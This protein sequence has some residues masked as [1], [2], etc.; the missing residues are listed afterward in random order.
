MLI[1][2]TIPATYPDPLFAVVGYT[3]FWTKPR[4]G[5]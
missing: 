2:L 4:D 1:S 5:W 3:S